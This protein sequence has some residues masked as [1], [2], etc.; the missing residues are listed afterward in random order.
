MTL[1]EKKFINFLKNFYNAPITLIDVG[2]NIGGYT[3]Y[4]INNMGV[5]KGFL[6]E[7]IKECYDKIPTHPYLH[8]YNI[9]LGNFKKKELFHKVKGEES[10]SSFI[11]RKK[12]YSKFK[13]Q[14]N[15]CMMPLERLDN[16]ITEHIN[17]LKID[18]EGYELE[19][20]KGSI[21]LLEEKKIDFIQIEYGGTYQDGGIKLNDVIGFLKK[22]NYKT[23]NFTGEFKEIKSYDDDYKFNNFYATYKLL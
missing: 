14:I 11:N 1:D 2:A 12:L 23:Y 7:P 15:T 16:I 9:G 19:V 18:T 3:Q 10:K 21:H 5:K 6:F 4:V 20:L 8:K 17:L 22:Y 13:D